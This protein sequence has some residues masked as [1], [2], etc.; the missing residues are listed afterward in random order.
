MVALHETTDRLPQAR[1]T[2]SRHNSTS[3]LRL[4]CAG[5]SQPTFLCV[6]AS[7]FRSLTSR[8]SHCC[9]ANSMS[10]AP[11]FGTALRSAIKLSLYSATLRRL[12]ADL[13]V[14]ADLMEPRD[15]GR[16]VGT[17]AAPRGVLA[18]CNESSC[19]R[20]AWVH[21][22]F[23]S[24]WSVALC[25][26]FCNASFSLCVVAIACVTEGHTNV[27]CTLGHTE[28]RNRKRVP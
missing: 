25:S 18:L 4:G 20:R 3:R 12:R 21:F 13:P 11:S 15:C 7:S 17:G 24:R 19:A 28:L 14:A 9:A 6:A 22:V 10:P 2:L 8:C 26:S 27:R 1:A 16:D 23:T 5:A